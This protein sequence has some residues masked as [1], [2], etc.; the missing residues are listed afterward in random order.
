MGRPFALIVIANVVLAAASG[1][2]D[3]RPGTPQAEPNPSAV[4]VTT[5]QSVTAQ[6]DPRPRS[7][8]LEGVDPCQLLNDQQLAS[9]GVLGSLRAATARSPSVLAGAPGCTA[10]SFE[11]Q[12]SFLVI[13]SSGVGLPEYL[14]KVRSNPTRKDIRVDGFPAVEEEGLTSVPERG[15]GECYVNVD[16]ADGQMLQVQFSQIGASPGNRLPIGTLCAKAGE[17]AEAAL[18][19]LQGG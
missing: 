2:A 10:S 1:C 11:L 13:A 14:S 5:T 16:V 8:Q 12:Y 6:P 19:T 15:S 17:I 4:T 3:L 7:V 9:L 18:A